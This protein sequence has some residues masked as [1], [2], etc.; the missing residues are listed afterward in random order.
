MADA[1]LF[2][3]L[4]PSTPLSDAQVAEAVAAHHEQQIRKSGMRALVMLSTCLLAALW[5]YKI[6]PNFQ[7]SVVLRQGLSEMDWLHLAALIALGVIALLAVT[8]LVLL[9]NSFLGHNDPARARPPVVLERLPEQALAELYEVASQHPSLQ[10]QVGLWL[11]SGHPLRWG[12]RYKLYAMA[13]R[14]RT[15]KNRDQLRQTEAELRA[16]AQN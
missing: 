6:V 8:Y 2:N 10:R 1:D 16:A 15:E 4:D 5:V 14:V 12:Q 9:T 3:G 13:E 7:L 11:Q